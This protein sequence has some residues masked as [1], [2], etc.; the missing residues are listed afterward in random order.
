METNAS[1]R[2]REPVN[3]VGR[4]QENTS[5]ATVARSKGKKSPKK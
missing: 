4:I 2:D 1:F 5:T 3:I